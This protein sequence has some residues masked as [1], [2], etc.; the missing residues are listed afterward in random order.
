MKRFQLYRVVASFRAYPNNGVSQ[1]EFYYND[2]RLAQEC[3]VTLL[4]AQNVV[5]VGLYEN[6]AMLSVDTN[7]EGA[8]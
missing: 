1:A 3:K 6:G 4:S 5:A 8:K 2:I 7:L